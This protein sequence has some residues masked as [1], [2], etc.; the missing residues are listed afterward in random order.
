MGVY[1]LNSLRDTGGVD[2]ALT[3]AELTFPADSEQGDLVCIDMEIIDDLA[4]ENNESFYV[5]LSTNDSKVQLLD[6]C[7]RK[8]V[9]IIDSDGEIEN[10]A[11]NFRMCISLQYRSAE[12]YRNFYA[13]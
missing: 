3:P 7:Q 2:Y 1:L 10:F 9:N 5:E 8:V 6:Y 13:V 12:Q 11:W 4:V